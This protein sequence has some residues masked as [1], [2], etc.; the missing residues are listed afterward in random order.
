MGDSPQSTSITQIAVE[1]FAEQCRRHLVP[2]TSHVSCFQAVSLDAEQHRQF[3]RE[4]LEAIP[5][6]LLERLAPL[7][8]VLVP[9]LEK[10]AA[11]SPG[12]VAFEKPPPQRLLRRTM[13]D[14]RDEIF[15]LFAIEEQD[16]ADYHYELFNTVACLACGVV[17]EEEFSSFSALVLDELN[18]GTRGEVDEGSLQLKL[19]LQRRQRLPRPQD[20]ADA[21]LLP[22]G[23]GGHA[24]PVSSRTLLRDQCGSRATAAGLPLSA[25]SLRVAGRNLSAKSWLRIVSGSEQARRRFGSIHEQ[26]LSLGAEV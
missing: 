2:L 15:L 3:L 7:R 18:R 13:F 23:S 25:Q 17:R 16:V 4:P 26:S 6:S 11:G 24:H 22:P 14:V 19:Q 12:F 8:L 20:Q 21:P 1:E 9:Y 10:G 5:T